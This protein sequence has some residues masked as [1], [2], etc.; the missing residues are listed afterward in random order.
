MNYQII[1]LV[2]LK[3]QLTQSQS[4]FGHLPNH[5]SLYHYNGYHYDV[6]PLATL[7]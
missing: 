6:W 1:L 2:L 5:Q 4:Y 7:I 3:M